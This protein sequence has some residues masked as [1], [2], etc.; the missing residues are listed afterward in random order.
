MPVTGESGGLADGWKVNRE[1]RSAAW[2]VAP[3]GHGAAMELHEVLDDRETKAEARRLAVCPRVL[4][5]ETLED[6][7]QERRRDATPVVFDRH[8]DTRAGTLRTRVHVPSA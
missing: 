5:P 1:G 4:L 7:R 8:G 3:G 2:T 6:E